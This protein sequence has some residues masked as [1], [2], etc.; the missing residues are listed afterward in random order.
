MKIPDFLKQSYWV[1]FLS[2]AFMVLNACFIAYGLYYLLALPLLLFAFYLAFVSLDTLF[3]ILIFFIPISVPLQLYMPDL[4]FNVQLPTD[5]LLVLIFFL[6]IFKVLL[7]KKFDRR[8]LLH[9]ISIA[10]YINLVWMLIT[11]FTSTIPVVSFKY[12]ISRIWFIVTFYFLATQIFKTKW[13][14]RFFFWTY[15]PML[16]VV[17]VWVVVKM[18]PSGLFN[19]HAAHSSAYPFF[20]DHTALGSALAMLLPFSI[21]FATYPKF[22]IPVRILS[23]I[24]VVIILFALVLS[25]CRAAWISILVAGIIFLLI[26]SRIKFRTVLAVAI[27]GI[28]LFFQYRS[29]IVLKLEQ[30]NQ[31]SS[32]EITK[33]VQSISN[34][35]T[36]VSNMERINRWKSAIRMFE[37]KPVFGWGPGTYTFK[38]A[39]YQMSQD[40]TPISTNQGDR[41]N[42]HSDYIGALADSG[43]PGSLS[44]IL[45]LLITLYSGIK[46]Y[47][48]IIDQ[49]QTRM[50]LLCAILGLITYYTH[51]TL[52]NF[53]DTDKDSSLFWGFTAIIVAIDV[54]QVRNKG[55]KINK[56]ES[57]AL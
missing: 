5:L 29:E 30:N 55:V 4:G 37:V 21:G 2:I 10:I 20:N 50:L 33:H 56:S 35:Q 39:P 11:C 57:P 31:S 16:M 47:S 36:D 54:Y 41:G 34:I 12:F 49:P 48:K 6:I 15:I 43:L 38:Y 51:A 42:A 52:N 45:I 27:I 26:V 24:L 40:R 19:E 44:F 18:L 32:K 25:Y 46:L 53:L 7:E 3:Y 14:I 13:G 17:I 23:S 22:K 28:V 1:V 9:P 8:I